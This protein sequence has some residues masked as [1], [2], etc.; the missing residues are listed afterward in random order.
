MR[1]G[2]RQSRL[3]SAPAV[4][5]AAALVLLLTACANTNMVLS[6]ATT[7]VCT[8]EAV[9]EWNRVVNEQLGVSGEDPVGAHISDFPAERYGS[10]TNNWY[11]NSGFKETLCGQL[12]HFNVY[13]GSGAEMDWNHFVLPAPPF[14][15]LITDVLPFKGGSGTWCFDDDWHTCVSGN[16]CMEAELTPDESFYQNPWFPKSTGD[17]VL[18]G[19]QMC[20][21]GPWIRECV[22]GHRPEIHPAELTWWKERWHSA[23]LFWLMA[24]QDDSNRF[25]T[26]DDFDI[27]GSTPSDW[28]EWGAAP[29]TARFKLAFAAR[30]GGPVVEFGIGEA[31]ARNVVTRDDAQ[32]RLDADDGAGHAIQY[33][34]QIVL[35]ATENQPQDTDLGVTFTDVCRRTDNALQGFVAVTTKTGVNND[36][37]EGYHV[38][39]V[40]RKSVDQTLPPVVVADVATAVLLR[41]TGDPTSLRLTEIDGRPALVG[42]LNVEAAGPTSGT[43]RDVTVTRVERQAGKS[44]S[45]LAY[46]PDPGRAGGLVKGLPLVEPATLAVELQPT[47]RVD[48]TWP[49]LALAALVEEKVE[50]ASEAS[51]AWNAVVK[52]AG[53]LSID[54]AAGLKVMRAEEVRLDVTPQYAMRKDG[55][56]SLEDGSPFV[57]RLNEVLGRGEEAEIKALFGTPTPISAEW[58]F[59]ATDLVTG[60]SVAVTTSES[61]AAPAATATAVRVVRLPGEPPN[62]VVRIVFP[63]SP[64]GVYE[65]RATAALTDV[66]GVT[67]RTEHRVYSHF[68]AETA[69]DGSFRPLVPAVAA[70]VGVSGEAV[71]AAMRGAPLSTDDP[72]RRDPQVRRASLLHSFS[73]QAAEDGRITID[74]LQALIRGARTMTTR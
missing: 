44:R 14:Q 32:A 37:K 36:G 49:G 23:D 51:Q 61:A 3:L 28:R 58:T 64:E 41:T 12:H 29:M 21:Y 54:L 46:A 72:R 56:P 38:L 4:V 6:S 62:E 66:Q 33:D 48:L 39:F 71:S 59:E 10:V 19:Q 9:A 11:P 43:P 55:R 30:P 52:A 42:D 22:H 31:F 73:R 1:E 60:R 70:A 35:R 53:G 74:E 68:L 27:E 8:T 24:L 2:R 17:S 40:T 50:A 16:D 69:A 5:P 67:S 34:G 65:V 13:D 57:E 45:D 15:H 47:G 63:R 25:D 20:F 26:E 7:P 18:E